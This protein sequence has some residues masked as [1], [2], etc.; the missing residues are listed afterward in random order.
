MAHPRGGQ[1]LGCSSESLPRELSAQ[2]FQGEIPANPFS[3]A[4]FFPST[5]PRQ[6]FPLPLS[7]LRQAWYLLGNPW[8]WLLSVFPPLSGLLLPLLT[9]K[10]CLIG[11]DPG[12]LKISLKSHCSASPEQTASPD[13]SAHKA[14]L[15]PRST[16]E[17]SNY[18][19][20]PELSVR[21]SRARPSALCSRLWLLY[22][23]QQWATLLWE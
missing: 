15:T 3:W 7:P 23:Q 21:G 20:R 8:T 6:T 18:A 4:P 9:G 11:L 13:P 1:Q 14:A 16:L 2:D 5:P 17:C 19:G 22:S 10:L 12:V